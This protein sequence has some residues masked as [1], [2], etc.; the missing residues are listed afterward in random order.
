MEGY[1]LRSG[2]PRRRSFH[3]P[4]DDAKYPVDQAFY[5]EVND[6]ADVKL[7]QAQ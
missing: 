7:A 4:I 5:M 1:A 3:E 6:Q 2:V